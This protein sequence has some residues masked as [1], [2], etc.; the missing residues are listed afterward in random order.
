MTQQKILQVGLASFGMSG[1]VFHAPLIAST[2][3]MKLKKILER[4]KQL[5]A[6]AY[7]DASI[8]R[9]FD[10]LLS[11]DIDLVIINTPDHTHFDLCKKALEAGKHVVVEKPF[12][13]HSRE[14]NS[15]ISLAKKHKVLLSVFQNRRWDSD[16]LTLKKVI[17]N[18][19]VG[20]VVE[21]E[22][23]FDRFRPSIAKGWKEETSTGTGNLYNLGSHLVDQ[24]LQLFGNPQYVYAELKKM[25]K[26]TK[27][28]DYYD[29]HLGYPDCKVRLTSSYLVRELGPRFILHGDKG[30]FIKYG[31]DTQEE[32]LKS[33]MQ[34]SKSEFGIE[35][36]STHG[37]LNALSKGNNIRGKIESLKGNY[38]AYYQDIRDAIQQERKPLVTAEEGNQVI[39]IIEAAVKSHEQG[40]RIKL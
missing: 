3:G 19:L 11:D 39:R 17:E 8:V 30:S 36:E 37:I 28:Y 34:P 1:K 40:T 25:R 14:G 2:A 7:P 38:P 12:V 29:L 18:N 24:A 27:I 22:S 4:T 15:L 6:K 32:Q 5:S 33:G 35:P 20:K 21:F 16:F 23:H 13:V 9:N 26:H 31:F 10:E